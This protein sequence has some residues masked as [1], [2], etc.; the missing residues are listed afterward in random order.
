MAEVIRVDG[1]RAP[2]KLTLT[3]LQKAVG[4]YI[5]CR[6]V[7]EKVFVFN[8]EGLIRELEPNLEATAAAGIP[9][10]GDVVVCTRKEWLCEDAR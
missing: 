4:G 7:G 9:L 5:E 8:E 6:N 3:E 2:V 10:V 1:T